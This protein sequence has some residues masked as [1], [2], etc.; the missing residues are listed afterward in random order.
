MS[1]AKKEWVK[2]SILAFLMFLFIGIMSMMTGTV[3]YG[4]N[5]TATK[6]EL[7]GTCIT[8]RVSNSSNDYY[9][10]TTEN[11]M[12]RLGVSNSDLTLALYRD[13][14]CINEIT[15]DSNG[16]VDLKAGTYYVKVTGTGEYEI[17]ANF[18]KAPSNDIEPNDTMETAILLT[19]GKQVSGNADT[20]FDDVDWYK[21]KIST[22]SYVDIALNNGN[23]HV[24][25]YDSNGK[26]ISSI[27]NNVG[28]ITS[29]EPGTYY[30]KVSSSLSYGYYNLKADIV[31]YP[32]PNEITKAV[33]E[34]SRKVSLTWSKSN[35]ADGYYLFYKTSETGRWNNIATIYSGNTTSYT[36]LYGPSE[37]QTY[38][39]GVQAFRKNT[40]FGEIYN[41]EDA[42][43]FKVTVPNLP[44]SSNANV[45][46]VSGK[47]IQV[48]WNVS[49]EANGYY[50]YRKANGGSYKLVK[51]IT[52]GSTLQWI[53]TSVKKGTYYTYRIV[54]YAV[55]DNQ[56]YFGNG[57]VTASL[58]LTGK[59][60]TVTS[61]KGKKNKTYN[62]VSWKK[63]SLATG[64]RVY[65]KEGSGSYKLV[66][67]TSSASYNDKKVKKGKKYT[68]KIQAYYKNYTYNANKKTY[69]SK[70]VTSG[71]SKKVS[72][73]R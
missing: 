30:I 67:T 61:V 45:K 50:I 57:A 71:Y 36:H 27:I 37:G 39:Y 20:V 47:A 41:Q 69:T 51:T 42:T 70:I 58:K 22:R 24:L 18:S 40:V 55:C 64:Y 68:Y 43:G 31:E 60:S 29:I 16:Y 17:S 49:G 8:D 33:Y 25:I 46:N 15:L 2:V 28:F 5:E 66:K 1:Y 6:I 11:G 12:V 54:P 26:V 14:E 48:S 21:F 72:V 4:A 44:T 13:K 63:N 65:R 38:Y 62:T 56:K 73:K 9:F 19:S 53:D 34:G 32:T 23:D 35:Y 10:E 59:L 52:A 3:A 7:D